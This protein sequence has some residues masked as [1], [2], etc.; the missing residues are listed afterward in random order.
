MDL[1][2][3]SDGSVLIDRSYSAD[4]VDSMRLWQKKC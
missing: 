4:Q 1:V 3:Q 2:G